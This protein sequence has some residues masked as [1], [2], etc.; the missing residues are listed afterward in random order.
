[1]LSDNAARTPAFGPNSPLKMDIVQAAVKTGTTNDWRDSWTVGYTRALAVGVW[2]GNNDNRPMAHVAGAIGAAPIWHNVIESVYKNPEMLSMLMKSGETD[3]PRAFNVA[4]G[5]VR[6]PVCLPSGMVPTNACIKVTYDWFTL[7]NAPQEPDTWHQWIPVTLHDNGGSIA[8]PGVPKSDTIERVYVVP[9]KEYR[10]YYGGAPPSHTLTISNE[11]ELLPTPVLAEPPP[12]SSMVTPVP[13][14]GGSPSGARAP[15]SLNPIPGLELA[16]TSPTDG[17]VLSGLVTVTGQANA[18]DFA[19]YR[20]EYGRAGDSAMSTIV[21]SQTRPFFNILA[22]WNTSGLPSGSYTL[23]LTL[24]TNSG[25]AVRTDVAVRV[26]SGLPTVSISSPTDGASVYEG[27]AITIDVAADGGGAPIAGVEIYLDGKRL[28][29]LLNPPWSARWAAQPGTHEISAKLF[30]SAGE[31]ISSGGAYVTSAGLRPSPTPTVAS[32]LWISNYT[33]DQ[34]ISPGVHD[35]WV[36]VSPNSP[37]QHV[38]IYIDGMPAGFAIGPGYRVNPNWTPTPIPPP[39]AP[40]TAT[41]DPDAAAT[42]TQVQ[43]TV[44]VESTI[45]AQATATRLARANIAAATKAAKAKATQQALSAEAT[46]AAATTS[47]TP[48]PPTATSQPTATPT[49]VRYSKLSDPMLGDY[50]AQCQFPPGH[51]RIVAIGYDAN[52][53]EVGRDESWVIVR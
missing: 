49:F 30:T 17:S 5:M 50:V 39:T 46:S 35:V 19:R 22:I 34:E 21:E 41:L 23:R 32:I 47:P 51:H 8:G 28:V 18:D 20:L 33:Y 3:V 9:P 42:A 29:S 1:M 48:L 31:S 6:R 11:V 40:P 16:I 2:V 26:G 53:K 25:E 10:A 7:N 52:N 45:S 15:E 24:E 27:E 14:L 13:D 43:A 12:V 38:D 4:P 37:V 36:D 44:Q